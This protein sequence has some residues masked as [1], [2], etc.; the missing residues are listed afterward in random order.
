M[1]EQNWLIG[2]GGSLADDVFIF[3]F[4]GTEEDVVAK[5]FELVQE[6]REEDE[7]SWDFGTESTNEVVKRDDGSLYAFG[8]YYDYHT[9]Y[10]ARP[11]D[12]IETLPPVK[13]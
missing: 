10:V 7:E 5:L 2:I 6:S 12:N 8:C 3:R 13:H 1:N 4:Q 9:D 11:E